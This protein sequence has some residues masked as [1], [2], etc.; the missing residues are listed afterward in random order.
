LFLYSLFQLNESLV[1]G[2][3]LRVKTLGAKGDG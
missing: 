2:V 3:T 1:N